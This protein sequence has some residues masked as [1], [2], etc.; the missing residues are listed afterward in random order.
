M[1]MLRV[2]KLI[3]R[4]KDGGID[5]RWGDGEKRRIGLK[6]KG[7]E[8]ET[9]GLYP[10][11]YVQNT[12]TSDLDYDGR[13]SDNGDYADEDYADGDYADGDYTDDGYDDQNDGYDDYY[14]DQQYEEEPYDDRYAGEDEGAY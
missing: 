10:D 2:G 3:F 12:D 8:E 1:A 14:D 11:E 6:R 7:S 13:F 5:Y 9:A 4:F